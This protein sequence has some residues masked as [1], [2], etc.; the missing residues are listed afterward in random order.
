MTDPNQTIVTREQ[1]EQFYREIG[2][3]PR[4]CCHVPLIGN[5]GYWA[6]REQAEAER[7]ELLTEEPNEQIEIGVAWMTDAEYDALPEFPGY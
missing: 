2:K 4:Y 3:R 5:G 6:T 7:R 1:Q